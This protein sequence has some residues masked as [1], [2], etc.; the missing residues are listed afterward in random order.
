M[1]SSLL[2]RDSA[3]RVFK[4]AFRDFQDVYRSFHIMLALLSNISLDTSL[5]D[6]L[7]AL[8][9]HVNGVR[10]LFEGKREL[11]FVSVKF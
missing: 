11:A 10:S 4:G 8:E 9:R 1:N 5:T 3:G 6:S 7:R 2:I